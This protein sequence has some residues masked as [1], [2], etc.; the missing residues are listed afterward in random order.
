MSRQVALNET[1]RS[2]RFWAYDSDGAAV[3]GEAYNSAG[4][5]ASVIVRAK[6]RIISTTALTLIARDVV[7][8]HQDSA[9]SEVGSGEY[10]IDLPD[11][12]LA[13][14]DRVISLSVASDAITGTVIVETLEV[15]LL[16]FV[17][18]IFT[19][20]T[21]L[22]NWLG[23]LAGKAS[24]TAT[25][26]EINAT[27]AGATYN[28]TTDSQEA[29]RDRGDFAWAS[30]SSGDVAGDATIPPAGYISA[31]SEPLIIGDD[32]I[33][34]LGNR[35]TLDLLDSN[36][37]AANVT[38]GDYSLSDDGISIKLLF[39]TSGKVSAA[40]T[41]SGTCEFVPAA[42]DDPPKLHVTLP[43][44]ETIN[45]TPGSYDMQAEAVWDD[46]TT[47]TFLPFGKVTFV[48]NIARV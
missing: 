17:S 4:M 9:F 15:G 41:L 43:R 38:F 22:A 26:A 32:Y 25:R 7:G 21:R 33:E 10:L 23:A 46:G 28:E 42:G 6:G 2:I 29:L 3:T 19:G 13:T 1:D 18:R 30:A 35:I 37:N 34:T 20:I 27:T 24:D 48:K 36:G 47:K 12:Y 45:A 16:S 44:T 39:H 5:T 40:A 8:T 14:A 31:L 11:S